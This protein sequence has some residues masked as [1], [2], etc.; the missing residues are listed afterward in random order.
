MFTEKGAVVASRKKEQSGTY[1]PRRRESFLSHV[2]SWA[3]NIFSSSV[4]LGLS[5]EKKV[6]L[7]RALENNREAAK[8]RKAMTPE[9]VRVKYMKP[10]LDKWENLR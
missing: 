4:D 3:H 8:K 2:F 5:E 7:T 1:I 9:E 6:E 10:I